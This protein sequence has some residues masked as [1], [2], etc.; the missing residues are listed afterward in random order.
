[1]SILFQLMNLILIFLLLGVPVVITI[2]L[3]KHFGKSKSKED[4]L[5]EKIN[6]LE[7]RIEVLEDKEY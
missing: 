2:L 3:L 4:Y 7:R 5:L 1:M 6:E